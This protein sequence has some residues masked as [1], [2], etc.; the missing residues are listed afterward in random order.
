M[1]R[2]E[3]HRDIETGA[4][5]RYEGDLA[6]YGNV[7][8][9]A[10]IEVRN[11]T[12]TVY[13][14]IGDRV[15]LSSQDN[16]TINGNAG[17]NARLRSGGNIGLAHAGDNLNLKAGGCVTGGSIGCNANIRCAGSLS[18]GE[19]GHGSV[20]LGETSVRF[21]RVGHDCRIVSGNTAYLATLGADSSVASGNQAVIGLAHRFSRASAAE[22]VRI[23]GTSEA[24]E[25]FRLQADLRNTAPGP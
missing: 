3:I 8:S 15:A 16:L 25:D 13:G 9:R 21:T 4:I 19:L 22:D 12:L 24:P 6:V 17:R 14:G 18:A 2:T 1:P 10:V 23:R 5:L 7:G 20:V 11:G